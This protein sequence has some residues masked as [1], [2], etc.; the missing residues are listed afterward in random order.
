MYSPRSRGHENLTGASQIDGKG[1]TVHRVLSP[2]RATQ[3]GRP[4]QGHY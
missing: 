2:K 4:H 1:E 3:S